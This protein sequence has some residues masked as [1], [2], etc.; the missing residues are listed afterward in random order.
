MLLGGEAINGTLQVM[1]ALGRLVGSSVI[2]QGQ[3]YFNAQLLGSGLHVYK[4]RDGQ[5][6]VRATGRWV[7]E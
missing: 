7:K 3:T 1:D 4:A 5:G 2:R 6:L